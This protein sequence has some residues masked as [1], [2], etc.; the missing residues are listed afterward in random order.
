MRLMEFSLSLL[1]GVAGPMV[2]EY[3]VGRIPWLAGP[4]LGQAAPLHETAHA[5]R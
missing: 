2:V 4:L 5:T 3:R 1:A